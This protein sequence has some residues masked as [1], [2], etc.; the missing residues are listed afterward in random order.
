M[1]MLIHEGDKASHEDESWRVPKRD[2][3]EVLHV[4]LQTERLKVAGKFKLG[5]VLS[6]QMLSFRVLIDP[7]TAHDSFSAWGGRRIMTIW[8]YRWR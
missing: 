1:G 2:L 4:L 6:Q 5:P 7:V 8:F 3:V